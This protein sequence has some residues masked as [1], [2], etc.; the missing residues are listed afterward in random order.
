MALLTLRNVSLAFGGA[1]LLDGVNLQIEPGERLCL[2][3]RNGTGKSTLMK[4]LN[5]ELNADSGEVVLRQG[6]KVARLTQEV[7]RETVGSVYDVVADGLGGVG[8]LLADYHHVSQQLAEGDDKLLSKLE[9]IQHELEAADGWQ[10]NQRVESVISRLKLPAESNFAELSGGMKRR[11]L[12]ARELVREPELLLLDEPTNHLDIEAIGW[13]EEFLL[14]WPGTL[15]FITHDRMFLQHLATR[16]IELDRGQL[17]SWPGDYATYL[18]R[19]EE[20]LEAEAQQNALF[21]KRLAQEEA[22]IRQGIKARRT[23]NEGRV[24]ALK[25]LRVERGERRERG[26]KVKMNLGEAERSG[27]LVIEADDIGMSY[28]G[29]TL[30]EHFSTTIMRGDRIG[31]LGPNGSGKSTLLQVLLGKLQPQQGRIKLGTNLE[32]AYFDQHRE[33][34]DEE[35]TVLDSVAEGSDKVTINGRDKHVMGYL[36]DFLFT[37]ERARSPVRTLSGGERNRLLLARLFTRP[38]NLLVMD[39]PT[40]DLDVETLELL[41]ELLLDW[42]GTLLLVSHDR[43]FINNVVTSTIAFE[44]DGAL[45]EYVGGYDD[46]L[47]QRSAAPRASMEVKQPPAKV[48]AKKA[49]PSRAKLS[50]KDQR[51]LDALPKRIEELE[52]ALE[53]FQQ[54]MAE[55]EYF[56]QDGATI[57]AER[58]QMEK[59]EQELSAAYARWEQLE[60]LREGLA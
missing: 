7:P 54:K 56:K 23:R 42:Q 1:P 51:E 55:P 20:A 47:R 59:S 29:R 17:T 27:K 13:L 40:N 34:L 26:G 14:D 2:V 21:D 53:A 39:E 15:L 50:Y 25:A 45:N 49:A 46:W 31:I 36:Q 41:E 5:G 28:D 60:A 48:E 11:V 16:I 33:Q 12:L 57:A 32:I 19:K 9:K 18:R 52:T 30:F 6:L 22:W 38:A 10:L 24:R 8:K 43:A 44:G 3:G 35:S 58:E 4:L 37:P